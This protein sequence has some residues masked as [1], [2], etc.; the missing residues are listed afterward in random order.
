MKANPALLAKRRE[1]VVERRIVAT[2]SSM[3]GPSVPFAPND[4]MKFN[5]RMFVLYHV[6]GSGYDYLTPVGSLVGAAIL[7][8]LPGR[9]N[10]FSSLTRLQ[11]AGTGGILAGGLGMGLGCVALAGMVN[12]KEPRLPF[13]DE[14]WQQ[15]VDGLSHNYRVRAMDAGVWLGVIAGGAAV[16]YHGGDPTA[17]RLSPGTLGKLQAVGLGSAVASVLTNVF[18]AWTK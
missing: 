9:Y 6:M 11:A 4:V 14:G 17:L 16:A 15:R 10:Y 3:D 5:S 7:P 1:Q 12:A 2:S 18:I 13:D 8:L